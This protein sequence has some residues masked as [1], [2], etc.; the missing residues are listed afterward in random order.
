ML[1]NDKA[2]QDPEIYDWS[3]PP[4]FLWDYMYI[5]DETPLKPHLLDGPFHH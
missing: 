2:V 1:G 3:P 5:A 4:F